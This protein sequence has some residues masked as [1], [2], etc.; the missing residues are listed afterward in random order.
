MGTSPKM[1]KENVHKEE[2]SCRTILY[3]LLYTSYLY[4]L[5]LT[6]TF[7]T[8]YKIFVRK[9][10][11]DFGKSKK[12]L[13]ARKGKAETQGRKEGRLRALNA[14]WEILPSH[15]FPSTSDISGEGVSRTRSFHNGENRKG[16]QQKLI[17]FKDC[18]LGCD[19]PSI[20]VR[21]NKQ[22]KSGFHISNEI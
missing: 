15:P 22:I 21:I 8:Q 3:S 5:H 1:K 20:H 9:N 7:Q 19:L 16:I 4:L 13:K 14:Q 11:I 12:R 6:L 17:N 2:M 18:T 10:C